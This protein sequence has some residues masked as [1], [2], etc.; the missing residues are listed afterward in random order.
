MTFTGKL[1]LGALVS[2]TTLTI[3]L[4][5][6]R[7]WSKTEDPPEDFRLYTSYKYEPC[8]ACDFNANNNA[9]Q[10]AQAFLMPCSPDYFG[11][12][13]EPC[14][15]GEDCW[16]VFSPKTLCDVDVPNPLDIFGDVV[17]HHYLL[18][19]SGTVDCHREQRPPDDCCKLVYDVPGP[20]PICRE[21]F[22]FREGPV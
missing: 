3:L 10:Y 4:L 7:A 15:S 9:W 6:Q 14:G 19:C 13:P 11:E 12:V 8:I 5:C 22:W 16:E 17:A 2:S 18:E 21:T 20:D 1:L